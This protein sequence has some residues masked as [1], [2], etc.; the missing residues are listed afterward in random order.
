M[1]R[2]DRGAAWGLWWP[3][4][5]AQWLHSHVAERRQARGGVTRVGGSG[6]R[7]REQRYV[8]A[9]GKADCG[10]PQVTGWARGKVEAVL[11][12]VGHELGQCGP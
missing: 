3:T 2:D 9:K 4:R 1:S 5:E 7:E 12:R 11:D 10:D 6:E 8:A